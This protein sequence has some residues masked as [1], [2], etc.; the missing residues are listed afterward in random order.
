MGDCK[1]VG[2][3]TMAKERGPEFDLGGQLSPFSLR[4]V[5]MLYTH[6]NRQPAPVSIYREAQVNR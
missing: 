6:Y 3:R 1:T 5:I 4:L 2:Q